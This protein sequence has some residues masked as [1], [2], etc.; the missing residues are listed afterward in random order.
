MARNTNKTNL[1]DY[2][3]NASKIDPKDLASALGISYDAFMNK[4][5]NNSFDFDEFVLLADCCGHQLQFYNPTTNRTRVVDP[6]LYF[7]NDPKRSRLI[8]SA[9]QAYIDK[10][11]KEIEALKAEMEKLQQEIADIEK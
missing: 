2:L 5:I 1:V 8:K 10:R 9:K 11:K 4:C 3:R 6:Q 7:L